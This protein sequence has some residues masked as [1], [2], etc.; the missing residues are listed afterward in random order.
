MPCLEPLAPALPGIGRSCTK[1]IR[2]GAGTDVLRN[3]PET[4]PWIRP[5]FCLKAWPQSPSFAVGTQ[6]CSPGRDMGQRSLRLPPAH[7]FR[8]L[9]DILR[10]FCQGYGRNR[11]FCSK[12]C[13]GL[14]FCPPC[15]WPCSFSSSA[16]ASTSIP[17][18]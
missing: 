12:H 6:V 16:S 17:L 15:F 8:W 5:W 10:S 7:F 4:C 14:S 13:P 9:L 18:Q 3:C 11:Q 2:T 1:G